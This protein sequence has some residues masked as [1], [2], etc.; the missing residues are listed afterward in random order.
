MKPLLRFLYGKGSK[1]NSSHNFTLAL[2]KRNDT[3]RVVSPK[4]VDIGRC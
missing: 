2:R 4:N 3:G 1:P